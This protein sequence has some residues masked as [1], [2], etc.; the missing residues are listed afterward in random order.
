MAARQKQV[1]PEI[2]DRVKQYLMSA[3]GSGRIS[4]LVKPGDA[5]AVDKLN[6]VLT[7]DEGLK[8][9]NSWISAHLSTQG[10]QRLWGAM[11][12]L[13]YQTAKPSHKR[14]LSESSY[15]ALESYAKKEGLTSVDET[16]THLLNRVNKQG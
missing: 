2:Y 4:E 12:S 9:L 14:R 3:I 15:Q 11:R 5:T 6:D 13:N 7:G 16:I 10:R 1:E 8:G